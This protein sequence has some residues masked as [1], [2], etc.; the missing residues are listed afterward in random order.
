[1]ILENQSY[2]KGVSIRGVAKILD[3]NKKIRSLSFILIGTEKALAQG[4]SESVAKEYGQN[5]NLV[6]DKDIYINFMIPS[7]LSFSFV[8]KLSEYSYV[9]DLKADIALSADIHAKADITIS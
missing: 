3:P 7:D 1:M 4:Q 2:K 5:L 9:V 6:R 8:G